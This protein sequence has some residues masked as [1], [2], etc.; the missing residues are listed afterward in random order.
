MAVSP[1]LQLPVFL[2]SLQLSFC[3][4]LTSVHTPRYHH[5]RHDLGQLIV[6]LEIH[7]YCIPSF[8]AQRLFRPVY[9]SANMDSTLITQ[10]PPIDRPNPLSIPSSYNVAHYY[11]PR[12]GPPN[13]SA[14]ATYTASL[15]LLIIDSRLQE[16]AAS[17]NYVI[18]D[19]PLYG[20]ALALYGVLQLVVTTDNCKLDEAK[21]RLDAEEIG[22][23]LSEESAENIIM[24]SQ[25]EYNI[26]TACLEASVVI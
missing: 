10:Y 4:V 9:R 26:N 5:Q 17:Y 14:M 2:P 8:T 11:N 20:Q 3:S 23:R 13:Y 6:F 21:I 24:A 16:P 12:A 22:V 19:E 25:N 15:K 7:R 1:V 18:K